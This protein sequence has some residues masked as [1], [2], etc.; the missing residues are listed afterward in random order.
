MERQQPE[1]PEPASPD[2]A[3]SKEEP[4]EYKHWVE[5]PFL[6]LLNSLSMVKGQYKALQDVLMDMSRTL[7][8]QPLLVVEH[9]KALPKKKEMEDLQARV[10][11]LL[12]GNND[13]KDQVAAREAETKEREE[14]KEQIS[15]MEAEVATAQN[16]M[17]K[18]TAVAQKFDEFVGNS[19]NVINKAK[20]YDEARS[21]TWA[22]WVDT[23][24]NRISWNFWIFMIRLGNSIY[25]RR[26]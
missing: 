2:R 1:Q 11:C 13:L 15:S 8:V 22:N 25:S 19:G 7:G 21:F 26:S 18:A 4:T 6:P 17:D 23:S 12:R 3:A 24:S 10:D 16:E 20:L 14:L 9:I 5:K